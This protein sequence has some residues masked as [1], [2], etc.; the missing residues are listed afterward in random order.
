MSQGERRTENTQRT[1]RH[2]PFKILSKP[3]PKGLLLKKHLRKAGLLAQYSPGSRFF[4]RSC[5]ATCNIF[6]YANQKTDTDPS[7]GAHSPNVLIL[8][9]RRDPA[10]IEGD[11]QMTMSHFLQIPI[12]LRLRLDRRAEGA[13]RRPR[14]ARGARDG[15]LR[16]ARLRRPCVR[17]GRR[18][19]ATP[20]A[21]APSCT[22]Q[23]RLT[24][25]CS[26]SRRVL[27]RRRRAGAPR[28]SG[29]PPAS[30]QSAWGA[31]GRAV[32]GA[33][34]VLGFFLLVEREKDQECCGGGGK[35]V[36]NVIRCR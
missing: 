26:P 18:C 20:G 7:P 14:G 17:R 16:R 13:L 3:N 29:R 6:T 12:L 35:V 21:R 9:D 27:P 4:S 1:S 2:A 32:Q 11:I 25:A 22:H 10:T 24:P 36:Q 5:N 34:C 23:R 19:V 15:T 33:H 31:R 8:A 28:L 30:R